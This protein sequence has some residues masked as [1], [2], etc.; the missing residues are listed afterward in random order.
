MIKLKDLSVRRKVITIQLITTFVVLFFYTV[1]HTVYD[2][3]ES[4]KAVISQL[5]TVADLIGA[6]SISAITFL[7]DKAAEGLLSSLDAEEQIV[8]GWICDKNG[9]IFAK[10]EKN[11]YANFH[12]PRLQQ[13]NCIC[14][15]GFIVV[16]RMIS[17]DGEHVGMIAL[18]LHRQ[19]FKEIALK[20]LGLPASVLATLGS[21][22]P[23]VCRTP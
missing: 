14:S 12:Y 9:A 15:R 4:Q 19:Q 10:Y 1:F 6:N 21:I 17:Y 20:V 2:L 3:R 18:R 5:T 16:T 8:N 7:D 22:Y 11:G 13:E 23:T